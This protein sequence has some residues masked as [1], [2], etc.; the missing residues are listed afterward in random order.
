[1][2]ALTTPAFYC[3]LHFMLPPVGTRTR[4][5]YFFPQNHY[6]NKATSHEQ[7]ESPD[8]LDGKNIFSHDIPSPLS[9]YAAVS[10]NEHMTQLHECIMH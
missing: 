6:S 3:Y 7:H 1:M 4:L 5:G 10:W 2:P 9:S 8:G